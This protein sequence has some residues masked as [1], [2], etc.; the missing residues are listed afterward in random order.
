MNKL[1]YLVIYISFI[2]SM[3]DNIIPVYVFVSWQVLLL[4]GFF[5]FITM[6]IFSKKK[7]IFF[8]LPSYVLL[9]WL[10]YSLF[11]LLWTNENIFVF[12]TSFRFL[13]VGFVTT[14]MFSQMINTYGKFKFFLSALT[15]VVLFHNIM[16]WREYLT[17]KYLFVS[18][19]YRSLYQSLRLPTSTFYNTNDL[20]TFLAISSFFILL[21]IVLNKNFKVRIF[22]IATYISS[23]TLVILSGSRANLLGYL[24]GISFLG[25]YNFV[26]KSLTLKKLFALFSVISVC[27][28]LIFIY[29]NINLSTTFLSDMQNKTSDL[30]RI[31]LIKNGFIFLK[32]SKFLGVG[33][34]NIELMMETNN[35]FPTFGTFP[36]HN[37]WFE[38]LV[39]S[40]IIVFLIYISLYLKMYVSS[41]RSFI[42]IENLIL[43]NCFL[44]F[45]AL[46]I[47][48][49]FTS[50]STSNLLTRGWFWMLHSLIFST[51]V[52]LMEEKN[53]HMF[54]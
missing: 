12:L 13:F 44:I 26:F 30:T 17:G 32:N 9:F 11:S 21:Y 27:I 6:K 22:L 29:V 2:L 42:K 51:Y 53:E 15:L 16:G 35:I 4:L 31:N 7:T 18:D 54:R 34:G 46:L 37:W 23:L 5:I 36:I 47:A 48:F 50:I 52:F 33:L 1:L 10:L 19:E 43:K 24:M 40:G 20:S 28:F 39:S 3:I 14:L 8:N 41:F 25:L 45:V 38:I 49:V